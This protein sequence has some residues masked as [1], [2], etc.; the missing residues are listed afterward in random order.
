MAKKHYPNYEDLCQL[1]QEGRITD[2]EYVRQISDEVT[3]EYENF[4]K[5]E[6]LDSERNESALHFLDFQDDLF[7]ESMS[8]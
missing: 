4:C 1:R 7:E 8:Y 6:G 2:V 3:R 5:D